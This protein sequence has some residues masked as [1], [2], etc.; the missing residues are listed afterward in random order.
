M[1]GYFYMLAVLFVAHV[2]MSVFLV[3]FVP[4]PMYLLKTVVD[5]V[6]FALALLGC[7]GLT[8]HKAIWTSFTWRVIF[9]AI[10]VIGAFFVLANVAGGKMGIDFPTPPV[11]RMP[12]LYPFMLGLVYVL[13][14]WPV[15][16]YE[17][18]LR[19]GRWPGDREPE[20]GD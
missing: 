19:K 5:V 13:F 9:Q 7:Y 11:T 20:A 6:L 14:A 2:A 15:I 1:K 18:A 3:I 17:Y 16:L 12:I 8:H 4:H 10:L